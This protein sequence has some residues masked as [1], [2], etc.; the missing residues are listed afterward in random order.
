MR[1]QSRELV[2]TWT[3]AAG[4]LDAAGHAQ[5]RPPRP[6][7]PR[8]LGPASR[9]GHAPSSGP[10]PVHRGPPLRPR[11]SAPAL[12]GTCSGAVV[13]RRRCPRPPWACLSAEEPSGQAAA[14]PGRTQE[15]ASTGRAPGQGAR[16]G[17]E[18]GATRSAV[19]RA[20]ARR[21]QS[22]AERRGGAGSSAAP[23]TWGHRGPASWPVSRAAGPRRP[24]PGAVTAPQ[25]G[26]RDLPSPGELGWPALPRWLQ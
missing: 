20:A 8:P 25:G 12:P 2:V 7:P 24:P 23:R 6:R 9:R 22:T 1:A 13:R 14:E 4:Q 3:A 5:K 17:G 21:E 18:A 26:R 15:S 19:L 16:R 11:P 10:A